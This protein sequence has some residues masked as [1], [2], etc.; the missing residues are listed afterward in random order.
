MVGG[1]NSERN[2]KVYL[3]LKVNSINKLQYFPE[4]WCLHEDDDKSKNDPD[5]PAPLSLAQTNV[6]EF[7]DLER[8][9][10]N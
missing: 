5:K 1:F 7:Q 10:Y 3:T 2:E 8:L 6:T 9:V 4:G